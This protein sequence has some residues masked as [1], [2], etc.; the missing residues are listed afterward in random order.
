MGCY[1]HQVPLNVDPGKEDLYLGDWNFREGGEGE[2]VV[3]AK[4]NF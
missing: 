3:E 1:L 2:I 4:R